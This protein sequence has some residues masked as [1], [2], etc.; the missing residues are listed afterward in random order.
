M[1]SNEGSSNFHSPEDE[2]E[3]MVETL[4]TE[5]PS[6][7]E[8]KVM[9]KDEDRVAVSST[10]ATFKSREAILTGIDDLLISRGARLILFLPIVVVLLFGL[11]QS[12]RGS[13]PDWWEGGVQE[14]FFAFSFSK[15][16]Y[17][18]ALTLMVTDLVLLFVLHYLLWITKRIFQ[19][20]TDEVVSTGVT[21]RS[22]HGYSEMKA[23]IDGASNQL[24]LTTTLMI[25]S[26][27]LLGLALVF[28]SE[29][30]GIPVLIALSTGTLLSGHSVYMVSNRPRFNTVEPWGL[31]DAFSPPMHPALLNRPFTDVIRSH[32][33]PL[34]AVRFSKY[35]SSF[36]NNLQKGV[37][38]SELQEY[39]LQVLDLFRSGVIEED[40]FH[41]ALGELVDTRTIEQIIN[42]P[43]LGEETLDRLLM[44]ARDRCAPFFRLN[45]RMRMHLSI[46]SNDKIW[47]DVDMENL[48]LGQ[49]NLFAFVLNQSGETQD[50]I[51]RVQTPDFRPNECVYR[52]KVEPHTDD[53]LSGKTTYARVSSSMESSRIV[54]QTLIPS[55]MGDA[56]VTVRLEDS[57]GN[58][59]SGKV[60]TSQVR[61]DLFTRLRMTTG[62]VFMFGA[63]LAIISPI[64][65]FVAKL[66]GL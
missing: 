56:T 37:R 64:L 50:L 38:L 20:E 43:E 62:A 60:L 61:S 27:G 25:F 21:F 54:W 66:L 46:Q 31:L 22:S 39:L 40:D 44:H 28:P 11:A 23:V 52:L 63:A 17:L 47:F 5:T 19:I 30:E 6:A 2:L 18:L 7:P 59:I 16:V 51:L 12:Y 13:E 36:S 26:T 14:L 29:T 24:N 55:S 65:P 35:V 10:K 8:I 3:S 49:A 1:S 32:V 53:S 4:Q 41:Q 34:L 33:D 15:S 57:S 45:D 9:V 58:L 48:T 42:H